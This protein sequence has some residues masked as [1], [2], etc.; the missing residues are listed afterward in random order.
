MSSEKIDLVEV[1]KIRPT[2]I[3]V[4]ST[5]T[6]PYCKM[7]KAY[8]EENNIKHEIIFVDTNREEAIKIARITGQT[9]VP[10]TEVEYENAKTEYIVGFNRQKLSSILS[11]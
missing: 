5:H 1:D 10:V 2:N 4:Y 9:G 3:K 11:L 8:L 6:C 7:E